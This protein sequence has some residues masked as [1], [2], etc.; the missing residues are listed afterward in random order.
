M[1]ET[2]NQIE[3][4]H[5]FLRQRWSKRMMWD[6]HNGSVSMKSRWSSHSITIKSPIKKVTKSGHHFR[7]ERSSLLFPSIRRSDRP[8]W[9]VDRR[10]GRWEVVPDE[11][12][13]EGRRANPRQKMARRTAFEPQRATKNM[14]KRGR[15]HHEKW[16]FHGILM[17]FWWDW[18]RTNRDLIGKYADLMG[19]YLNW[20]WY[21]DISMGFD[22][23]NYENLNLMKLIGMGWKG[24]WKG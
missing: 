15:F 11:D 13:Q 1:F 4:N 19:F 6:L 16:W 9:S 21:F 24:I 8:T 14:T 7:I 23:Q 5:W 17:G 12:A 20:W 3:F 2:T 10:Q 22:Q 18:T